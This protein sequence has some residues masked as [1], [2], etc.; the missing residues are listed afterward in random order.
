MSALEEDGHLPTYTADGPVR[1]SAEELRSRIPGWGV[2]LD[3]RDRP[4]HPKLDFQPDLT[5]AHWRFPERQP[6]HQPRERSIEHRFLTPVFGTAQ[7]R[8]GLSGRLRA[9]AYARWSEGRTAHWLTLIAADRVDVVESAA[10]SLLRGKPDNLIA[11]TGV[12]AE[13]THHGISSRFGQNRTDW[14]HQALDP[15][16]VLGPW[17]L[18]GW[19]V[20]AAARRLLR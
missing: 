19:G 10:A 6:E 12:R 9:L 20:V 17:L 5:G 1:P 13:L 11:E 16:I 14:R 15:V 7:P 2:D 3:P 8:H 18:A 4:S